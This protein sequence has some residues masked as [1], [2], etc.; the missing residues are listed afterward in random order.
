[1]INS[2]PAQAPAA[3][4]S[5]AQPGLAKY[6]STPPQDIGKS[7]VNQRVKALAKNG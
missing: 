3:K 6:S 4:N 5:I 2:H 1:M 7:V